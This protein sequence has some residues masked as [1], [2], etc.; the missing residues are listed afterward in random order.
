MEDDVGEAAMTDGPA[1]GEERT[2]P[3]VLGKQS[4]P[5]AT[6]IPCPILPPTPEVSSLS[7][8]LSRLELSLVSGSRLFG[9][10]LLSGIVGPFAAAFGG[11]HSL[12]SLILWRVVA[13]GSLAREDFA[14]SLLKTTMLS[15]TWKVKK[16]THHVVTRK[17][18]FKVH[19]WKLPCQLK[20]FRATHI[21]VMTA[22]GVI[23][24]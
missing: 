19:K 16:K 11:I 1:L 9:P 4:F 24:G 17:C 10:C 14:L 12:L 2:S 18:L 3:D 22:Q 13:G 20:S 15:P 21:V 7:L 23:L 8:E 5:D 6:G